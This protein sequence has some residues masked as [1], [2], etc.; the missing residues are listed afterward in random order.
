M[1]RSRTGRD[2]AVGS[3]LES[4]STGPPTPTAG[5]DRGRASGPAGRAWRRRRSR[6][7]SAG[8]VA[9]PGGLAL[10]NARLPRRSPRA[11][12]GTP[13]PRPPHHRSS[14]PPTASPESQVRPGRKCLRGVTRR[15]ATGPNSPRHAAKDAPISSGW[16]PHIH[17]TVS[18]PPGSRSRVAR[19]TA[20]DP[21]GRSTRPPV[22]RLIPKE[23]PR[24]P[25]RER[26]AEEASA[27]PQAVSGGVGGP[28]GGGGRRGGGKV[29][30]H[31]ARPRRHPRFPVLVGPA[32]L[33]S[34]PRPPCSPPP[35]IDRGRPRLR[36]H[37][38]PNATPPVP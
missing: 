14:Q 4:G 28:P 30:S 27:A 38:S 5:F 33:M 8:V 12:G 24:R 23:A 31:T 9:R 7:S 29:P 13:L 32:R 16:P 1:A 37:R 6:A 17:R 10:P 20:P 21:S 36:R 3:H 25:R 2:G 19:R 15:S 11:S 18:P 34:P 35:A 22:G 26:L